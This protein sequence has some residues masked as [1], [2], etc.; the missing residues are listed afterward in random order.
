MRMAK[1]SAE[2]PS[3]TR[4]ERPGRPRLRRESSADQVAGHVRQ[5]IMDGELRKGDR[6]RQD[7]IADELGVSRIPVR[8][9]IIALDREGWV[10]FE[11][12]RGAFVT[13]LEVEDIRDHY[14]LR[15]LVFG[16][17]AK[18]VAESAAD[19]EITDLAKRYA[20]MRKAEDVETFSSLN[21]RFLGKLLRLSDSPRLR[22]ALLVTPSII[23]ERFFDVVPAGRPIQEKGIGQLVKHLKARRGDD[24]DQAMRATLRK[25]GEAVVAA[26]GKSGLLVNRPT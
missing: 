12:N 7:E 19:D 24:A 13:G 26:F 20:A 17:A 3:A 25:Q 2:D 5:L 21:E 22:A 8:E 6:L 14:E 23:P 18:R 11:A 15:G 4:G 1:T 9:A 16:L 10:S